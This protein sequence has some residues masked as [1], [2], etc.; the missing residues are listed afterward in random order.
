MESGHHTSPRSIGSYDLIAELGQGGM[1]QVF[2]AVARGPAGFVKLRVIKRLKPDLALDTDFQSMFL[3]EARLAA[4]LDHPNIVHTVEVQDDAGLPFIAMEYIEGESLHAIVRAA[5]Q[6]GGS[7]PLAIVL[8]ILC[9]ALAGLHHAHEAGDFDGTPLHIVHR[10]VT[11]HNILVTYD[12]NTKVVDFGIAKA[13]ISATQT[14]S[15]VIKGK[16][17]YL[18]PEQ[19]RGD[20]LDRRSDLFSIGVILYEALT[21]R[22]M[23]GDLVDYQILTRLGT[24]ALPSITEDAGHMPSALVEICRR[25]LATSP[26]D[27]F[28]SAAQFQEAIE[29]FLDETGTRVSRKEVGGVVLD[30]F[31]EKRASMREVVEQG[32]AAAEDGLPPSGPLPQ[33]ARS[34]SIPPPS[35]PDRTRNTRV[36]G[37]PVDNGRPSV[38]GRTNTG[39][40]STPD[41]VKAFPAKAKRLGIASIVG[42]TLV[43]VAGSAVMLSQT[44]SPAAKQPP[45]VP[46]AAPDH[47][48]IDV[49][50]RTSPTGADLFIDG[51]RVGRTPYVTSAKRDGTTHEVRAE[52]EGY[53]PET[54]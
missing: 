35:Y 31:R 43:V 6:R 36:T 10:D 13:R 53:T 41:E 8:H 42:V 38:H 32:L 16:I 24:G 47:N 4:R 2:L 27:R 25:A 12:G 22:R 3:D 46:A 50:F 20:T 44:G 45:T 23:W 11:P 29:G 49:A 21:G 5:R 30:L 19:A 14:A 33:F 15:G 28:D 54:I 52:A 40:I 17:T 26:T 18:S 7:A 1:A 34:P 39:V 37:A 48:H 9:D 51:Q